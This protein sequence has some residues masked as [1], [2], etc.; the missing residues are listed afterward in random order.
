MRDRS[1]QQMTLKKSLL[2]HQVFL[3]MCVMHTSVYESMAI[4]FSKNHLPYKKHTNSALLFIVEN[5]SWCLSNFKDYFRHSGA[6]AGAFCVGICLC[7]CK[8]GTA[9]PC[10]WLLLL[11][12]MKERRC[13]FC[14]SPSWILMSAM[15]LFGVQFGTSEKLKLLIFKISVMLSTPTYSCHGLKG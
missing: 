4:A 14:N 10:I 13:R 3:G 6:S 2:S 5:T 7:L 8:C 15:A 12:T 1:S 11:N 9:F